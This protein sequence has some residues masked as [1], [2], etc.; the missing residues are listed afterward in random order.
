MKSKKFDISWIKDKFIINILNT[1]ID[2]ILEKK[3]NDIKA[4]LLFGSLAR[5]DFVYNDEH[6]SDIDLLIISEN[7]PDDIFQR[8]LYTANLSKS[9]GA[10]IHKL[11]YT[12]EE[13]IKL[14]KAHRAFFLEIIKY[15]RIIFETD[16][17]LSNLK[18]TVENIIKEKGI[19]ETEHAWMWPQAPPGSKIEW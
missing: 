13:L 12:S 9:V 19:R 2:H 16:G 7:L 10:G 6:Q 14:I 8:K 15:G 3:S 18:I 17:F 5:D 1:F 11:W 4:I